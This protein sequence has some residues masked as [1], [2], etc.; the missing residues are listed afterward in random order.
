MITDKSKNEEGSTENQSD[1]FTYLEH[2]LVSWNLSKCD[3]TIQNYQ[4]HIVITLLDNQLNVAA[5][6][7]LQINHTYISPSA[8]DCSVI[9]M[10]S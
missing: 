2:L 7:R 4:L 9:Y 6:S 1:Q 5:C 8:T 3:Q 10:K